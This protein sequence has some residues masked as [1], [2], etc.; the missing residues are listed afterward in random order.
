MAGHKH[1][2]QMQ[3]YAADAEFNPKPWEGWEARAHRPGSSW[4]PLTCDPAWHVNYSYRRK[5]KAVNTNGSNQGK[6]GHRKK[7]SRDP[8]GVGDAP[9]L[10]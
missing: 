6:G 8:G 9:A 1:W 10:R 7:C 5:Q 4:D 3:E 2:K